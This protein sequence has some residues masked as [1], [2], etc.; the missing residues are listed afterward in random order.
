MFAYYFAFVSFYLSSLRDFADAASPRLFMP[1]FM[2]L[3]REMPYFRALLM[4]TLLT[5]FFH[6][7][8]ADAAIFRC[9]A[10]IRLRLPLCLRW[11]FSR[12][13][14]RHAAYV[15]SMLRR[16]ARCRGDGCAISPLLIT[17]A[18]PLPPRLRQQPVAMSRC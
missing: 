15:I 1:L 6:T 18:T 17:F 12:L 7:I 11:R 13:H 8:D 3:P 2:Y 5:R 4:P 10:T 16:A 14:A 9:H